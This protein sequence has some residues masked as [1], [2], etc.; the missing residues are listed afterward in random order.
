MDAVVIGYEGTSQVKM[1][2][3]RAALKAFEDCKTSYEK[4]GIN[5]TNKKEH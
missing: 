2:N 5:F 1:H 3:Y 4:V